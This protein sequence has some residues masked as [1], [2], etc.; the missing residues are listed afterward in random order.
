MRSVDFKTLVKQNP[1]LN[2]IDLNLCVNCKGTQ[3]ACGLSLCPLIKALDLYPDQETKIE[4]IQ[5]DGSIFGPTPQ[6]FV[7][8]GGYPK[9]LTGPM[10]SLRPDMEL[11]KL[12][13][14][15]AQWTSLDFK[16]IIDLRFNLLRGKKRT[17]IQPQ[18]N[19]VSQSTQ[20]KLIELS[21]SQQP[22]EVEGR[23][24]KLDSFNYTI[25]PETQPMGPSGFLSQ[26]ELTSNAKI[27]KRV[28]AILSDELQSKEQIFTLHQ[29]KFDIY[30]LQGI[31]SSGATGLQQNARIVPT[32]WSITAVDDMVGK[33]LIPKFKGLPSI[34]KIE[35]RTGSLLG[36]NYT[37]IFLPGDLK[38]ENIEAW[39]PGNIFSLKASKPN[40]SINR[41]GYKKNEYYKGRS[42]YASQVGGY[43]ASRLAVLEHLFKRK[44]QARVL[45]IREITPD[46]LIPVG[47]WQVREGMN[48]TMNSEPVYF[49]TI[50]ELQNYLQ[51]ILQLH[52]LEYFNLSFAFT[53][54]QLSDFF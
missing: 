51:P 38:F 45:V 16:E 7:G 46:Y 11:S 35:M 23:F 9:V 26:F 28:D 49:D 13:S 31:F 42:S 1:I 41:D 36:N 53:Q 37:A 48:L 27:P 3:L 4:S 39:F 30:Y 52:P 19:K 15:P 40:I 2:S 50:L 14:N 54:S 17:Y 44:R 21:L 33:E 8:S 43:Y 12:A 5:T 22:V 18:F 6:I 24:S 20:D 25:S 10:T 29:E 32:R 47:V 34:S